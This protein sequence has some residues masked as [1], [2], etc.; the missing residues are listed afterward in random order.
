M[1]HFYQCLIKSAN[2]A[3]YPRSVAFPYKIPEALT[4]K[5][6]EIT[7]NCQPHP[8]AV[9]Y[10]TTVFKG[11]YYSLTSHILFKDIK[12]RIKFCFEFLI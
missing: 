7:N 1:T 3:N 4:F 2:K 5:S 8:G 6:G 9:V 10:R 12:N 11:H